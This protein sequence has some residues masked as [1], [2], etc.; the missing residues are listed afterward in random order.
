MREKIRDDLKSAMK[1]KEPRKTATLM[2]MLAA[3]QERDNAALNGKIEDAEIP[4]VLS[5][6][7]RQRKESLESYEK[8]GREDLAV[9]EREEIAII[10]TYLPKQMSEADARAA[11]AAL[12][13]ELGASSMKDMGKVMGA[14]KERFAGQMDMGK[15]NGVVKELL[16]PK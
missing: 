5:K 14:L 16:T 1:A 11:V 9:V 15:A 7:I 4:P 2:L 10:E 3:I 8:H 12:V 13:K 6:M